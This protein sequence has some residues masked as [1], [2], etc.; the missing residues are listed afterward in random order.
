MADES[1]ASSL[2]CHARSIQSSALL[3]FAIYTLLLIPNCRSPAGRSFALR[4]RPVSGVLQGR[5]RRSGGRGGQDTAEPEG[6]DVRGGQDGA[7]LEAGGGGPERAGSAGAASAGGRAGAARGEEE[8]GARKKGLA[9]EKSG[10]G[11][12]YEKIEAHVVSPIVS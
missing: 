1:M 3:A 8:V 4:R 7:D 9:F 5:R 10:V 2:S 6:G 11:D 12:A